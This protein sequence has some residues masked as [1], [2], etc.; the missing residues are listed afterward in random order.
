MTL[1]MHKSVSML[2]RKKIERTECE[3]SGRTVWQPVTPSLWILKLPKCHFE[4]VHEWI[5]MFFFC[6]V[7]HF[8]FLLFLFNASF[9]QE[10]G[11]KVSLEVF[12]LTL[13]WHF[14][15]TWSCGEFLFLCS[16]YDMFDLSF[17]QQLLMQ[18]SYS[19]K[20]SRWLLP[21]EVICSKSMLYILKMV[22]YLLDITSTWNWSINFNSSQFIA[23]AVNISISFGKV[24]I[25]NSINQN[26]WSR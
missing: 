11:R 18:I 6:S 23:L 25:S 17:H 12:T 19:Q 26:R 5:S 7:F 8:F 24:M 15:L 3:Y 20:N 2:V 13:K 16:L 9:I 22:S 10:I 21:S 1:Y 4:E 14:S